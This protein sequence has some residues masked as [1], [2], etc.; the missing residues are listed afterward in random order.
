MDESGCYL[1][2]INRGVHI[3]GGFGDAPMRFEVRLRDN[4]SQEKVRYSGC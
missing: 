1:L 2:N 3:L 4:S